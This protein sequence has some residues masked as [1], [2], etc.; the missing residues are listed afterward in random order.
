MRFVDDQQ[1]ALAIGV[2]AQQFL[3]QGGELFLY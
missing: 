2:A 3:V 1:Y